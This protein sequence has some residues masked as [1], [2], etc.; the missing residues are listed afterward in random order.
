[1]QKHYLLLWVDLP[2]LKFE[3]AIFESVPLSETVLV[4][5]V[6]YNNNYVFGTRYRWLITVV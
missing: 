1:M 5:Y 3:N 6:S 4:K 2:L